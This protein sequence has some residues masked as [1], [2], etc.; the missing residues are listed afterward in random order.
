M[1]SLVLVILALACAAC[2]P[3]PSPVPHDLDGA[4]APT[5]ENACASMRSAGCIEG[6]DIH[7]ADVLS[8]MVDSGLTPLDLACLTGASTKEAARAC[9]GGPD[10][11]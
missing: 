4:I 2:P 3:Q 8:H 1:R 9:K 10:C 11:P 5:P 6:A 7:C